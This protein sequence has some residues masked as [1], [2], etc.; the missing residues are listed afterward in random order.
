MCR[1]FN[2]APAHFRESSA[3][4]HLHG[5]SSFLAQESRL[6]TILG[7]PFLN[8]AKKLCSG[9]YKNPFFGAGT[10]FVFSQKV[11]ESWASFLPILVEKLLKSSHTISQDS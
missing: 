11:R 6:L 8:R 3:V 2:S 4:T 5:E 9:A 1:R 7:K 10:P